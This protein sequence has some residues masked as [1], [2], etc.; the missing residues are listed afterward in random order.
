M[1]LRDYPHKHTD[2]EHVLA[3]LGEL[4]KIQSQRIDRLER[5]IDEIRGGLAEARQDADLAL[6]LALPGAR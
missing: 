4:C 2:I 3:Q 6:K 1:S 5:E